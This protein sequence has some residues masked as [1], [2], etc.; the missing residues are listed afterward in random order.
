[1]TSNPF[2]L[3]YGITSKS[4]ISRDEEMGRIVKAFVDDDSMLSYLITGIRGTGKTVLLKAIERQLVN[5]GGWIIVN[6]N[7][8]GEIT[9]SL[10]RKL[11]ETEILRKELKKWSVS[12]NLGALT[13][14]RD[15]GGQLNDPEIAVEDFLK[16][17]KQHG[18]KVLVSIDEVND[19]SEFRRFINL[20][21]ILIG[22]GLPCYL[23]MTALKENVSGLINDKAMTFL[24]RTPKIEL[25]PLGLSNI[26]KEYEDVLH[27]N[28]DTAVEMAKLTK[29]Y[30]FAFQVLGYLFVDR[31]ASGLTQDLLSAYDKYLWNNGYNKFWKDRTRNE[32]LFLIALAESPTGKKE[33][34]LSHFSSGAKSYPV[35]RERLIEQGFLYSPVYGKLDFVLPRFAEFINMVKE[36]EE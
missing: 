25:E 9:S 24:S 4:V 31:K 35:Y 13:F 20:F 15:D 34:I 6:I 26:A 16:R 14:T 12:I 2:T 8:Q 27:V 11:F 36:F 1:M 33:E 28:R 7:P 3:M 23:L 30:A 22:K 5:L 32:R 18:L 21:Q 17:I 19:T 10:A 29:G